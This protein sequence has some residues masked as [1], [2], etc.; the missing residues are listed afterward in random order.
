MIE[1][2]RPT[3]HCRRKN[4][5]GRRAKKRNRLAVAVAM[6]AC[7]LL[8]A[9]VT[10][11]AGESPQAQ[12][13]PATA[14][15]ILAQEPP[16][17]VEQLFEKKMLLIEVTKKEGEGTLFVAYVLFEKPRSRVVHLL[18]Q[19]ERQTEYRPELRYIEV[20]ERGPDT[21]VDEHCL[22]VMFTNVVYRLRMRRDRETERLSWHLD[23]S[24]DN[25]L[26]RMQGFWELYQFGED[27]TLGRFGSTVDVGRAVP[28]MLQDALSRK[29]VLRTVENTRKWVDS[30]GRWRP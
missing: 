29:T 6:L 18:T 10:S 17:L 24:F 25:D 28:R 20:V 12:R 15:G 27:R 4:Q 3:W 1:K 30:D 2:T 8:L 23:P 14:E 13:E 26:R 22:K 19:P 11:G 21:R 7:L 5:R 9:Q 16:E